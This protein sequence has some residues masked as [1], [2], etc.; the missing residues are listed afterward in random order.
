MFDAAVTTLAIKPTVAAG[1]AGEADGAAANGRDVPAAAEAF[2]ALL[3]FLLPAP[4]ATADADTLPATGAAEGDGRALPPGGQTLPLAGR[5][6]GWDGRAP[7]WSTGKAADPAAHLEG[8]V[9]AAAVGGSEAEDAELAKLRAV[10]EHL[11]ASESMGMAHARPATAEQSMVA[12]ARGDA[13]GLVLDAA[14]ARSDGAGASHVPMLGGTPSPAH[15]DA[16]GAAVASAFSS[17][18]ALTPGAPDFDQALGDR[19]VWMMQHGLNGTRVRVH[20][21]HL[22]PIDIRLRMDGDNAQITLSSPHGV[23]RDALEQ[24]LP[25]LRDVLGDAGVTLVRADVDDRGTWRQD[26]RMPG[27]PSDETGAGFDDAAGEAEARPVLVRRTPGSL[28]LI[29]RFA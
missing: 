9:S 5:L 22:G 19:V 18:P 6:P 16:R 15:A 17:G 26:Q 14:A 24:A 2:A 23:A 11:R 10:V 13:S 7:V 28:G 25:R 12:A 20:P 1:P 8:D 21:E 3:V 4:P 27:A 29:D